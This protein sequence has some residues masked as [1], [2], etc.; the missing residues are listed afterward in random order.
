MLYAIA[1]LNLCCLH[2]LQGQKRDDVGQPVEKELA[3]AALPVLRPGTGMPDHHES[4][5]IYC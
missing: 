1:I 2:A 4:L 3:L 5:D